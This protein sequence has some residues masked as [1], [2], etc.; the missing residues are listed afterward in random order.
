MISKKENNQSNRLP[1]SFRRLKA[2]IK[3]EIIQLKRD[4]ISVRLP[5]A[6]PI[7]MML[8]FG[9]VV[10]TEVDNISTAV[11]DMSQTV[12]SREYI[13]KFA[14]SGYFLVD[15]YVNS[16]AELLKLM[17]ASK[18]KAGIIIQSNFAKDLKTGKSADVQIVIDGSDSTV[19]G[20]SLNGSVLVS[21]N[22]SLARMEEKLKQMGMADTAVQAINLNTR[23]LYNPNLEIT[24]FTI[25]GLVGLILQNVTIMLTAFSMVREKERGTIEQLMISPVKPS[26]L[27]IGKLV[28]YVAIGYV[29]FLFALAICCFWFKVKVVGSLTLLLL[30][31]GL[32]VICSLAIGML[33]STFARTQ[34]QAMMMLV[35]VLLPSILLSG[36]MFPIEAMPSWLQPITWVIPLTYFLRIDRGIILKDVGMDVLANDAL[37]LAAFLVILL[38]I[39]ILKFKKNLD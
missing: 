18:V 17:D 23:V 39:A 29:G 19:A 15:H 38:T 34:L 35:L 1:F 4:K 21:Q 36:F 7:M 11:F 10:N 20:T 22:Y 30:L 33:I 26:E 31:G 28:P 25:P 12:E 6:M 37:S 8:L 9:Y 27:I 14:H 5:I 13:D 32:F 16:E 2:I 3:K 24:N